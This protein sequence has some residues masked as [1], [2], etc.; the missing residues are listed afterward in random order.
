MTK[1][2]LFELFCEFES[3][4]GS[5]CHELAGPMEKRAAQ[6]ARRALVAAIERVKAKDLPVEPDGQGSSS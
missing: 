1:E 6:E 3:A 5:A 2:D 4:Y